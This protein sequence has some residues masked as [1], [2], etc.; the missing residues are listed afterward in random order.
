MFLLKYTAINSK[1]YYLVYA[2]TEEE[3][4]EKLKKHLFMLS[5]LH[6]ESATI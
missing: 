4:I 3:A 1:G 2:K 5:I 6:I